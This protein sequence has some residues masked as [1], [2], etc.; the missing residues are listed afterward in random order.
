MHN[1]NAESKVWGALFQLLIFVRWF[2][3]YL[4]FH[5]L[6]KTKLDGMQMV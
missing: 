4:P 3:Y 2:D 5:H 1:A 6:Q